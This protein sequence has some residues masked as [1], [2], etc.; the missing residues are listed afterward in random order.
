MGRFKIKEGD[1]VV[2]DM[3]LGPLQALV[4]LPGLLLKHLI[5]LF[6]LRLLLLGLL[7]Y[8]GGL[9]ACWTPK[10]LNGWLIGAHRT[11]TRIEGG[12]GLGYVLLHLVI[13]GQPHLILVTVDEVVS[14]GRAPIRLV[15]TARVGRHGR[16]HVQRVRIVLIVIRRRP[17][18]RI[19]TPISIVHI[20]RCLLTVCNLVIIILHLHYLVFRI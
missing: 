3:A 7:E 19:R 15:G 14:D 9:R 10:L 16:V 2:R 18:T 13:V 12:V 11:Q 4:R 8:I 1:D 5:Q 6:C 20:S 17:H